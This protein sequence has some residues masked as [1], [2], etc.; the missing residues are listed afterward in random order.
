MVQI[1]QLTLYLGI[2][3]VSCLST[4]TD[5]KDGSKFLKFECYARE[6]HQTIITASAL[7]WNLFDN[8]FINLQKHFAYEDDYAVL[9]RAAINYTVPHLNASNWPSSTFLLC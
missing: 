7:G 9:S 2:E 1:R 5:S 4:A 6:N 8:F 3:I